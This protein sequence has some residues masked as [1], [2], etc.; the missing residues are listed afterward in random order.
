M[1]NKKNTGND[2]SK[3]KQNP[4]KVSSD[5]GNYEKHPFF[6][7]KLNKAKEFVVKV[8]LPN[9]LVENIR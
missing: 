5:V 8:G 4:P 1:P 7:K 6:V 2:T 9:V 3:K